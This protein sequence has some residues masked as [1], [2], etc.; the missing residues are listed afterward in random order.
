[1]RSSMT[2][3]ALSAPVRLKRGQMRSL[4]TLVVAI[5][6]PVMTAGCADQSKGA[7]LSECRLKHY[8]ES[9]VAQGVAIPDCMRAKSFDV[10]IPC[11]AEADEHEWD[12]RV[13]AFAFNNPQCYRPIGSATWIATQLSPM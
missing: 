12:W 2:S 9:P 6:L 1:M 11:N 13:T 10:E 8:L 7:A 4:L 3:C 5:L